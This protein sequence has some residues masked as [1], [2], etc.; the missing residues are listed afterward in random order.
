M[1]SIMSITVFLQIEGTLYCKNQAEAES[2]WI[3]ICDFC[4]IGADAGMVNKWQK[5][6]YSCLYL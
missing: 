3:K 5:Q 4:I 1:T 6:Y 2:E